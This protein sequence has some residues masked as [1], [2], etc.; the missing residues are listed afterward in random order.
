MGMIERKKAILLNEPHLETAQS[1]NT[2]D[3]A[4]IAAFRTDMATKLK[5]LKVYFSPVQS[6]S[7][8]PSPDNVRPISGH[9][10][11]A[12]KQAGVNLLQCDT[13]TNGSSQSVRMTG[14]RNADGEIELY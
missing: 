2:S 7:G 9:T 8:D 11:L 12:V 5:N 10:G 6:G 14:T 1:G 4:H 13:F 3:S